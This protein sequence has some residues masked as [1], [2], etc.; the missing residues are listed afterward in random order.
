MSDID[1]NATTLRV[2]ADASNAERE[3]DK[4]K[5][6]IRGTLG[7]VNRFNRTTAAGPQFNTR[8]ATRELNRFSNTARNSFGA[9]A[10]FNT[11]TSSLSG[12][13]SGAF[14]FALGSASFNL[15][16]LGTEAESTRERFLALSESIGI[17]R[18]RYEDLYDFARDRGLQFR[19]LAEATNQLRVV[20]FAGQDLSVLIE[21]IGVIA[22]SSTEKVQRI[23]RALGQMRAFGRVALEELNQLTEAGV[24]II[25][26]LAEQLNVAEGRVRNL[27][28]LGEIEFD[29][30]RASITALAAEGSAFFTASEAQAQTAQAEINR[31]KNAYFL[32][33][34]EINDRTIPATKS[35]LGSATGI[36]EFFT[37]SEG[38]VTAFSTALSLAAA[39]GI[40]AWLLT[41]NRIVGPRGAGDAFLR[42]LSVVN[43]QLQRVR[44]TSTG[45]LRVTRTLGVTMR[46]AF[47]G[48]AAILTGLSLVAIPLLVSRMERLRNEAKLLEQA[49]QGSIESVDRT[50]DP[51][52]FRRRERLIDKEIGDLERLGR[53]YRNLTF[54]INEVPE[55]EIPTL[56]EAE[57]AKLNAY[58]SRLEQVTVQWENQQRVVQA[59][60][61]SI[62][63]AVNL[64]PTRENDVPDYIRNATEPPPVEPWQIYFDEI[65]TEYQ[66]TFRNIELRE[67]AGALTRLES[68]REIEA[69]AIEVLE[70]LA[71]WEGVTSEG[72]PDSFFV[73]GERLREFQQ[74]IAETRAEMER[75]REEQR[76]LRIDPL[77]QAE[78][79]LE[80]RV[81]DIDRLNA[82]I[83]AGLR[84][85]GERESELLDINRRAIVDLSVLLG[86]FERADDLNVYGEAINLLRSRIEE[87]SASLTVA[88]DFNISFLFPEEVGTFDPEEAFAGLFSAAEEEYANQFR[89][90]IE[91]VSG[92][93]EFIHPGQ[94]LTFPLFPDLEILVGQEQEREF[95]TLLSRR[96]RVAQES[97][98]LFRNVSF[99]YQG[100][101]DNIVSPDLRAFGDDLGIHLTDQNQII[102][103][104]LVD[105]GDVAEEE[106]FRF[107]EYLNEQTEGIEEAAEESRSLPQSLQEAFTTEIPAV[108]RTTADAALTLGE[109]IVSIGP[110]LMGLENALSVDAFADPSAGIRNFANSLATFV[111]LGEQP[112]IRIADLVISTSSTYED[113]L[114]NFVSLTRD[115]RREIF[116][117]LPDSVE[118]ELRR[119]IQDYE[120]VYARVGT[121]IDA[122]FFRVLPERIQ[123]NLEAGYRQF[124]GIENDLQRLFENIGEVVE[125]ENI[126]IAER[127]RRIGEV[128]ATDLIAVGAEYGR[129]ATNIFNIFTGLVAGPGQAFETFKQIAGGFGEVLGLSSDRVLTFIDAIETLSRGEELT[130]VILAER[131]IQSIDAVSLR[132]ALSIGKLIPVINDVDTAMSHMFNASLQIADGFERAQFSSGDFEGETGQLLRSLG[133]LEVGI[134]DVGFALGGLA[135]G[136]SAAGLIAP[137]AGILGAGLEG[138]LTTTT[139]LIGARRLLAQV[140]PFIRNA[141]NAT[142]ALY[143]AEL[144]EHA[145][146]VEEARRAR[147]E[148]LG[149]PAEVPELS[150]GAQQLQQGR[151]ALAPL[152]PLIQSDLFEQFLALQGFSPAEPGQRIVDSLDFSSLSSQVDSFFSTVQRGAIQIV[153]SISDTLSG[154]GS[155]IANQSRNAITLME[156]EL[157]SLREAR[158]SAEEEVREQ[159]ERERQALRERLEADTISLA[160]Y[161]QQL[162]ERNREAEESIDETRKAEIEK[163]NAIQQLRHEAEVNGF[164]IKRAAALAD[165]A[166]S[167]ARAVA[168]TFAQLG[169]L[170]IGVAPIIGGLAAAQAAFV[171]A[172]S[173][174]AAPREL[175][176]QHGGVVTDPTRALIGE[177]GPEAVIPLD[178]YQYSK[179]GQGDVVIVINVQG[180]LLTQENVARHLRNVVKE[181]I[182]RGRIR[183][184]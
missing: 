141:D 172:E 139:N 35:L 67:R 66:E 12:V 116:D 100:I 25:A 168:A 160:E 136:G 134:D 71:L 179:R 101:V 165:I 102:T 81:E 92:I 159:L 4:F 59:L 117:A 17:G 123:G 177:A 167:T 104:L 181:E 56:D 37:T 46:A 8:T 65:N 88:P 155:L 140:P 131:A 151:E 21:E 146:L 94:Q 96:N 182:D 97:T 105:R 180:D 137:V 171:L 152:A 147:E 74:I 42:Q 62:G 48:P 70:Q 161:Y 183:P 55:S 80:S 148:G 153:S 138:V 162:D 40:G 121:T 90:F 57:L 115:Q 28:S 82:Q 149:R 87:F 36:V 54:R 132:A 107:L 143:N 33:A 2:R 169:P 18:A 41:L 144:E 1:R 6:A 47:T 157:E 85:A 53:E 178:E 19:G 16:K 7:E 122:E 119:I 11:F 63:D 103:D 26:A 95:E 84:D 174:P 23:T 61:Q 73:G 39:L 98:N 114:R 58:R 64:V 50:E 27:V 150:L 109:A 129:V 52:N 91:R 184:F 69:A 111:S 76:D 145:R 86:E 15:F 22:G 99:E 175:A 9:L 135:L 5:E 113:F 13:L 108:I 43:L 127:I 156:R 112:F 72:L 154:I 124:L 125:A 38:A 10:A 126:T 75:L 51:R 173:P 110:A 68:L 128:A 14:V 31:L 20:G 158:V 34:D 79:I 83:N 32:L 93:Q 164:N 142:L 24:P 30:V 163:E 176:L 120:E 133:L 44:A 49:A 77:T 170:A 29:D 106:A 60:R 45:L 78:R 3:I 166:I 130:S 118:V 89:G